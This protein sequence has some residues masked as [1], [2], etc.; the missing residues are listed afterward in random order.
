MNFA[1]YWAR[2]ANRRTLLLL[3]TY[4]S[5]LVTISGVKAREKAGELLRKLPSVDEMLRERRIAEMA[6][7]DSRTVVTEAVRAALQN[8]RDSI[9]EGHL[10]AGQVDLAM[11]TL[12]DAVERF[13]RRAMRASLR[14]VI[15]ATGVILHT[16][17][18]RAPIAN[19]AI[20]HIR[21]VAPGYSN[22]E[23]DLDSGERGKRDVHVQRLFAHLLGAEVSTIVV[24]N[25][26]AA[27]LLALNSLAEGGEVLVSRGE[28]V[29]IGGSFRIPDV[30]S[31]SGASL[32]EVGTTNRT[33]VADYERAISERTKLIL[34]VHRSNFQIV[35]FTEQP[36]L[37]ELATLAHARGLPVMEDLGS[38]ALFDLATVGVSGEPGVGES[39]ATG[40]DVVTYSGDKLLGGPQAGILSGRPEIITRLRGNPLFR[41]LRVDKLT[42]A[43]LEATLLAYVRQ[44]YDAVPALRMMRLSAEDIGA[45]AE[46]IAKQLPASYKTEVTESESVI[47]GGAAPGATLKTRVLVISL[48]GVSADE[49]ATRLRHADPPVI[50]RVEEDH[51]VLDLRT[52]FPEQDVLVLEALRN[53]T[54]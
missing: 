29:E 19:A 15:N 8:L 32:R 21:E 53:V 1:A 42:Y 17:L 12:P 10:K 45:R 30:M 43:A 14:P 22:L 11:S 4:C 41:A 51:V 20:E 33:R 5:L 27:V 23:F 7:R 35:G 48:E 39:L 50:A 2:L 6:E 47:G 13:V 26:A 28:L 3:I 24:N 37:A 25:N 31:K 46:E 16:N 40:V 54:R 9:L 52:V 38:G 18:G 36:S 34:R 49:L 44:D